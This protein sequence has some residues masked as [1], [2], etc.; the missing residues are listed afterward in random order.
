MDQTCKFGEQTSRILEFKPEGLDFQLLHK[1]NFIKQYPLP[2]FGRNRSKTLSLQKALNYSLPLLIFRSS[3]GL[4]LALHVSAKPINEQYVS[5]RVFLGQLSQKT[6]ISNDP[7][8]LS[9]PCFLNYNYLS[10]RDHLKVLQQLRHQTIYRSFECQ[11][12]HP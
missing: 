12:T 11:I 1:T 9:A 6:K 7:I 8:S 10:N 5:F 4:H 2:D 3:Y